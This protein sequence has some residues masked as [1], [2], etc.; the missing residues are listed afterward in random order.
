MS[1]FK[2]QM[3]VVLTCKI[4]GSQYQR[5]VNLRKHMR[6]QH[7]VPK[8]PKGAKETTVTTTVTKQVKISKK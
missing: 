2:N 4:C 5:Q 7:M 6:A 1:Q 3:E 8:K